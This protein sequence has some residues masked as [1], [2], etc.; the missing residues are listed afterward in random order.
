MRGKHELNNE[1]NR[2]MCGHETT[3]MERRAMRTQKNRHI[4]CGRC[5]EMS[6][7]REKLK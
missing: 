3:Q 5:I 1:N 4:N 2:T 7:R 6:G